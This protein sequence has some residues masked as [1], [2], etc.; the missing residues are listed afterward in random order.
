MAKKG[1]KINGAH[2]D[3]AIRANWLTLTEFARRLGVSR[4]MVYH[5]INEKHRP[6]NCRVLKMTKLLGISK[7]TLISRKP[8]TEEE[9]G[10]MYARRSLSV[11]YRHSFYSPYLGGRL[12]KFKERLA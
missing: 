4:T 1:V 3:I 11:F 12:T 10:K 8:L 7:R 6:M 5:W 9:L 2:L